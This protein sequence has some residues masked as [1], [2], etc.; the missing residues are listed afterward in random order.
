MRYNPKSN[1]FAALTALGVGELEVHA[2]RAEQVGD[3]VPA[4]GRLYGGLVGTP[5]FERAEMLP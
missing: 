5:A 3:P 4:G 2:L 1:S